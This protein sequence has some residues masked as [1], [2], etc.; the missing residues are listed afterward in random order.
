MRLIPVYLRENLKSIR[1]PDRGYT[2]ALAPIPM[3]IG[4]DEN[5]PD[6]D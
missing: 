5:A 1:Q 2:L 6:A 4:S 3:T